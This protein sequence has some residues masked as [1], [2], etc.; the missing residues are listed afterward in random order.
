MA[1]FQNTTVR[2]RHEVAD[3]D[4]ERDARPRRLRRRRRLRRGAP[5]T[6]V[7]AEAGRRAEGRASIAGA[8]AGG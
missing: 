3:V 6:G 2:A 1:N 4:V 8:K 7:I 5:R